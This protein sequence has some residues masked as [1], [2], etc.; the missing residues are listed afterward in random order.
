MLAPQYL[1][2]HQALGIIFVDIII[3]WI[4][5]DVDIPKVNSYVLL[6]FQQLEQ[7]L[8]RHLLRPELQVQCIQ[9]CLD[10]L[11]ADRPVLLQA[12][13]LHRL[14]PEALVGPLDPVL[15]SLRLDGLRPLPVVLA[16]DCLPCDG[17]AVG[18][19]DL[20]IR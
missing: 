3:A 20:D 16:V 1:L 8:H 18:K 2:L 6:E 13:Q 17:A 4:M 9:N 11:A 14:A 12:L 19:L 5:L 10:L 7:L 15:G